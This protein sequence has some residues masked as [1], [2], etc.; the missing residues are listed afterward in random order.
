MKQLSEVR[1]TKEQLQALEELRR[2]LLHRFEVEEIILFG[3]HVQ[4]RADEESDLDLL[5]LTSRPFT[6]TRRHK[7]TDVVFEVNLKHSTNISTLVVDR[8]A[9]ESGPYSVMPIRDEI[10]ETGVRL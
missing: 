6:R 2:I 3:S 7:I 9:W 5:I 1:L 10:M 8:Q 4:D